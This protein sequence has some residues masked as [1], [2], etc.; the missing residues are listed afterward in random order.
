MIPRVKICGL[1][2]RQDVQLC[3]RLGVDICGFVVGYPA[4]VPWNLSPG[5]CA[6]LLPAVRPPAR[7]CIVTGGTP[8]QVIPLALALRPD[9]VQLHYRET[10]ADTAAIVRALSPWGI[11]VVKTVPAAPQERRRQFG[12][13]DAAAIARALEA[14]GAVMVLVDGRGAEDAARGAAADLALFAQVRRAAARPVML[15]GGIT[16]DN[17]RDILAAAR[18]ALV[19]VMTGVETAPGVKSEEKLARLL[20]Q[21][22]RGWQ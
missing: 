6:A 3:C 11:G 20:A 1:M 8:A 5:A 4:P 12:T 7:S 14:A 10:L 16:P 13:E 22:R 21:V 2:R 15:G 18:P 17:C 9:L 19:D